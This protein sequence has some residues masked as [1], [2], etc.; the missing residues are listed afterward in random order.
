MTWLFPTMSPFCCVLAHLFFISYFFSI[1]D[2]FLLFS[3]LFFP[4]LFLVVNS[5]FP[6]PTF[7]QQYPSPHSH[8]NPPLLFFSY[9]LRSR[10]FFFSICLTYFIFTFLSF[11]F[12]SILILTKTF[13]IHIFSHN[14]FDTPQVLLFPPR[15]FSIII[16][17]NS[18]K[19][20]YIFSFL[21]HPAR[22]F[23]DIFGFVIGGV[24]LKFL[25]Y[26]RQRRIPFIFRVLS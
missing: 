15:F 3:T 24:Q 13:H 23:P 21:P 20:H 9:L 22:P 19:V 6:F 17:R 14:Q 5:Y 10:D 25:L 4:F 12:S 7:S 26:F 16:C 8:S 11:S 1:N 2:A 18:Q